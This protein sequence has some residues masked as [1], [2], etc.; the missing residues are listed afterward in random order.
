MARAW[1]IEYDGALYHVL[2]RGNDQ[3]DIFR[4]DQDRIRFLE[5]VGEMSERYE[6]DIFAYVLMSNHYHLLLK[7][8]RSNLSKGMQWLGLAYTRR[9][10]NRHFR[11]GHL[12]QGRFKSILVENDA[13]LVRLSCYIHRN[14]LRAKIV[15]RL[16]EYRWSSYPVYAYGHKGPEWLIT[17]T[18]LSQ[19]GDP[20][21]HR[22]YREKVQRYSEEEKKLLEDLKHGV[23]LGTSDFVKKIRNAFLPDSPHKEIP[24]CRKMQKDV[25]SLE[26]IENAAKMLNV[27]MKFCQQTKRIP[28][29]IKVNR[30]LLVFCIWKTGFLTNEKIG[31]LFGVSYSSISHIVRSVQE[32]LGKDKAFKKKYLKLYSLFKI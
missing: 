26:L 32:R 18:I 25:D 14:P 20:Y 17:E 5:A 13:Y 23:I 12:F 1:R 2:S 31:E 6:M 9:F 27:D 3:Q 21:A 10:N 30:D 29:E 22:A 16:A 24:Q 15:D 11:S 8:N 4:N 7:T 28:Q 19:F